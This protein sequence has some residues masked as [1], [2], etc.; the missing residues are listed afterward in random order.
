[1]I[2]HQ[3][4]QYGNVITFDTSIEMACEAAGRQAL[5]DLLQPVYTPLAITTGAHGLY[6]LALDFDTSG[7]KNL[8]CYAVKQGG[9]LAH[10]YNNFLF[11]GPPAVSTVDEVIAYSWGTGSVSV[12]LPNLVSVVW[13]GYIKVQVEE[14][15]PQ[16]NFRVFS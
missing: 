7:K 14:K 6:T 9:L 5:S 16:E 13:Q 10:Y 8:I 1:M 12:D 4:D 11:R 2:L 15:F 3:T